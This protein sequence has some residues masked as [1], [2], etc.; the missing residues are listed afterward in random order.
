LQASAI[1]PLDPP[2]TQKPI[3][4]KRALVAAEVK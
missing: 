1:A 4:V 2:N 3:S